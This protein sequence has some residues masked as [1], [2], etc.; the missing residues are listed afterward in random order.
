M[1]KESLKE[2]SRV[3]DAY[4][5]RNGHRKTPERYAILEAVYSLEGHFSLDELDSV[6]TNVKQFPVSRAT[7]YNT[8]KLFIQLRLVVRHRF[9]G[10]T[11]YEACYNHNSHLHQVCT[12]CGKTVE[13]ESPEL[14]EM[15]H[16]L[17]LKRFHRDGFALYVYGI[18]NNCLSKQQR[19]EKKDAEDVNRKDA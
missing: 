19:D 13:I 6:M 12:T 18:C 9:Q 3:L 8:L 11:R 4:L 5:E 14:T 1:N 15:I 10:S 16:N 2:V 7:L 17:P